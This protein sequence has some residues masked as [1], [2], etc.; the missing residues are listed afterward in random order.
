MSTLPKY[1]RD[2]MARFDFRVPDGLGNW[3]YP[4]WDDP[5]LKVEFYDGA[6]T[7]RVTAA[8]NGSPALQQGNDFHETGFPD[9]GPF[10]YVEGIPLQEFEP[11]LCEA[12]VYAKVSG[13]EVAPWPTALSAFEVVAY[14]VSGKLYTTAD[15]VRAEAPGEWPGSITDEMIMTAVAD[16]SRK[17]D[18]YL[19][20]CYQTPF[21]GINQGEGPPERVEAITRKLAANQCL[22]WMGR[23]NAALE[24]GLEKEALSELEKMVSANGKAPKV[25]MEG[26]AGPTAAYQGS[27]E[28]KDRYDVS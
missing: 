5:D 28:R 4:D 1:T 8:P 27:L 2:E 16:A 6:D 26:Y 17:V 20:T 19:S 21:T 23:A 7:L 10:I 12:L 13:V 11:G 18:S 9:G 3:V 25:R 22:V 15:R 14:T 24:Q